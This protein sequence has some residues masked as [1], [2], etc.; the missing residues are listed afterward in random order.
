MR[1]S[2][3]ST[4][5]HA[6]APLSR[7]WRLR[8]LSAIFL[9]L[10]GLGFAQFGPGLLGLATASSPLKVYV[11]YMD[12]H[13]KAFSSSQPNPWP[14]KDSSSFIGSPCPNYPNATN[15]WDAAA[16]R[17]VNTSGS[18]VTHVKVEVIITSHTYSLWG[19]SDTVQANGELVLTETG[20]QNSENFDLS[21]FA[22]NAYNGGNKAS[23]KNDG[24]I[25][26]VK[27][28]IGGSTFTYKDT[29]QVLNTRGADGGHCVNGS[30]VS[31]RVDES[32]LWVKISG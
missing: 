13:S 9:T 10:F 1:R 11:G 15:C 17:L 16:I 21:D 3:N 4:R 6:A 30:F 28:T 8:W 31:T 7:R 26:K 25:P 29:G 32:H 27:V 5:R 24:A 18:K 23:C 19:S 2:E 20:K 12:T 22:P 14:Y